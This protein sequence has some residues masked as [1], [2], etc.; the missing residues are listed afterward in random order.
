MVVSYSLDFKI[1]RPWSSSCII[2]MY[3]ICIWI[4][5]AAGKMSNPHIHTLLAYLDAYLENWCCI[6]GITLWTW[7]FT[8]L[9]ACAHIWL[10]HC[11]LYWILTMRGTYKRRWLIDPDL[12]FSFLKHLSVCAWLCARTCMKWRY[13]KFFYYYED[14]QSST[15]WYIDIFKA[16]WAIKSFATQNLAPLRE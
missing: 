4:L 9:Y 10:I 15:V 5:Y 3:N 16:I 2:T 8:C 12:Y 13:F 11:A 14:P 1:S 7:A 6:Y